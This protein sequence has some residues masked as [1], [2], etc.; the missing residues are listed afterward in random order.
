MVANAEF[1]LIRKVGVRGPEFLFHLIIGPG[2]RIRVADEQRNRRSRRAPLEDPGQDFHGIFFLA[3]RDQVALP[4][5]AAIKL[6]L[7]LASLQRQARRTPVHHDAHRRSVAFAPGGDGEE[8][9]KGIRHD[10]AA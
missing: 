10:P 3:R 1:G 9:S 5:P 2:P 4:R 7:Y 6:R 8:L